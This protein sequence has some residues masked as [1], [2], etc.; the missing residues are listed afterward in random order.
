MQRVRIDTA[1]IK[2]Y[3]EQQI[4]QRTAIVRGTFIDWCSV[5]M[6]VCFCVR[7]SVFVSVYLWYYKIVTII[8]FVKR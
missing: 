7:V 3:D 1:N 5:T 6:R 8:K 2:W 4:I